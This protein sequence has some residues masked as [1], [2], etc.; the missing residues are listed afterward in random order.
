MRKL[1]ERNL[2]SEYANSKAERAVVLLVKKQKGP[3]NRCPF[4]IFG[5]GGENR[6]PTGAR[7]TG[8]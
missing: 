8:F 3:F 6:T 2:K 4:I 7:P 5:A 1:E